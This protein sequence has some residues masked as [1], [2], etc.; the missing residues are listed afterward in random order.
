MN[1]VAALENKD[2]VKFLWGL[3]NWLALNLETTN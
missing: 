1:A 2:D 3:P